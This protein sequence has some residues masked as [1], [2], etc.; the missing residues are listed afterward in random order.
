V[1]VTNPTW[2]WWWEMERG[3]PNPRPSSL[4]GKVLAA[5]Q[6]RGE[7]H[8]RLKNQTGKDIAKPLVGETI[9]D[10]HPRSP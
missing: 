8:P 5:V 6:A 2:C 7:R 4:P 10:N 3:E 1:Q 9:A